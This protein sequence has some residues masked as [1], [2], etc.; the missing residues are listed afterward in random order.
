MTVR[1][2]AFGRQAD[3]FEGDIELSGMPGPHFMRSSSGRPGLSGSARRSRFW[4]PSQPQ[5]RSSPSVRVGHSPPR[6]NPELTQ[7]NARA[8]DLYRHGEGALNERPH[9]YRHGEGR[10]MS[11]HI[12]V[13]TVRERS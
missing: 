13:D 2:N 1:R 6:F 8:Q 5:V 9:L 12:F 7:D 4:L 3:S 11:G 10:L